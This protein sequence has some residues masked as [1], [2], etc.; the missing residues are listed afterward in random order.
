ELVALIGSGGK[1][2]LMFALAAKMA[3]NGLR[4]LTTTTTKIFPPTSQQSKI[5]VV[6]RDPDELIARLK[7][8]FKLLNHVTAGFDRTE[9]HKLS[10][11]PPE[12]VDELFQSDLADVILVEADGAKGCPFKAP[13]AHEPVIPRTATLVI[14]VFGLSGLNQPLTENTVF[15]PERF[16]E[17]SGCR[18]G[19]IVTIEHLARILTA[20]GGLCRDIP[21]SAR[22]IPFLNQ[23]EVMDESASR[24]AAQTLSRQVSGLAEKILWGSLKNDW[25][26]TTA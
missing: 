14:P 7:S 25:I 18:P 13:A 12:V 8:A 17:I 10:G 1:T 9:N 3:V 26:N 6:N 4:V 24:A 16:T 21:S 2:T 5:V 23:A 22:V 15:R 19:E 11:L 20:P